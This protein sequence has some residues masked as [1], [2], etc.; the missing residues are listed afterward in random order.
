MSKGIE[1]MSKCVVDIYKE[2][3]SSV[4]VIV[5]REKTVCLFLTKALGRFEVCSKWS[6]FKEFR[7]VH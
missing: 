3:M 7:F 1:V 4:Y 6:K 2:G 5:G